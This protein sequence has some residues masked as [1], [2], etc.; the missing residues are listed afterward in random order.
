MHNSREKIQMLELRVAQ[1]TTERDEAYDVANAARLQ[2]EQFR[3]LARNHATQKH[4]DAQAME[5]DVRMIGHLIADRTS[6]TGLINLC[7][8]VMDGRSST[9]AVICGALVTGYAEAKG[10]PKT[11][12]AAQIEAAADHE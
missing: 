9:S 12:D 11:Q 10:T 6:A 5:Q 1:L 3:D 7:S 4:R 8:Q 2:S